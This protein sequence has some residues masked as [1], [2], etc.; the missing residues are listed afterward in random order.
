[1]KIIL[2]LLSLFV[3]VSGCDKVEDCPD[4]ALRETHKDD[5]CIMIYDPVCGCDGKTY[6]ND[7]EARRNGIR[8]ER[9]GEC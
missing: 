8:V 3:V 1:M 9:K 5:V 2:P 4:P 6:G 7:C